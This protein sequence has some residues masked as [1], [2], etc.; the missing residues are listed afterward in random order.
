MEVP[1]LNT[2]IEDYLP[3]SDDELESGRDSVT[4]HP[5]AGPGTPPRNTSTATSSA[6]K[7]SKTA[8]FDEVPE[9]PTLDYES[10]PQGEH[11]QTKPYSQHGFARH[12]AEP[13]AYEQPMAYLDAN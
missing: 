4:T 7:L 1:S 10:Y 2:N 3:V 5:I 11:A 8:R 12:V 6:P 9:T 13:T